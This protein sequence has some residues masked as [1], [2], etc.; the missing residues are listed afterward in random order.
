MRP[1]RW[2]WIVASVWAATTIA[3]ARSDDAQ[4]ANLKA[5]DDPTGA[6]RTFSTQ[7]AIDL[8]GLFFQSLGTNGRACGS[9]HQAATGWTVT[10]ESVQARFDATDGLDPIF[11]TNDGS[12]SPLADVST[13]AARRV[14]YSMLLT[15]ALIRVGIGLPE[16]RD[17]DLIAVDDPYGYASAAELS[18]F[19]RPLPSTNLPFL[20]TVMW[21]GRESFPG[22]SLHFDLSD[23]ANGAVLGH[24]AGS[25]PLTDT[26]RN[27]IVAFETS[28]FTAQAADGEAGQ[29]DAGGAL[30]GPQN[31]LQFL[32]V[33]GSTDPFTPPPFTLF[34]AWASNESPGGSDDARDAVAR[35]EAIFNTRP[36]IISGVNGLN[37]KL[38]ISEITGTCTTCHNTANIGNHSTALPVDIGVAAAS[39]RTPDLP[40][41]TFQNRATGEVIQT[42]D[43]GRALITG[44]W[45]DMSKF[46]G[47]ILRGVAGRAPY[48]HNGSAAT[49][50]DVVEF[51]NERFGLGLTDQEKA[52][53][54]A[55]LRSL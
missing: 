42:T 9:C 11:R 30:G 4:I 39:R 23:Q 27:A 17:F 55:F 14:A 13:V 16:V 8:S 15:K 51:Y 34:A 44:A 20:S 38:G 33:S 48:F 53:L 26:E 37:D 24:A 31:I 7:G 12:N 32:G 49:L 2:F 25:A 35:G 50:A 28:L 22:E 21:D 6:I 40:L 36:I 5:F 41:Y 19:R 47:P 43:P 1:T 3:A 46:K 18:L 54:I 45:K 10:P 52:D 29:L